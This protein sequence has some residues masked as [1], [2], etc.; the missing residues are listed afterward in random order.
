MAAL[1]VVL[2][3]VGKVKM[4]LMASCDFLTPLR[5]SRYLASVGALLHTTYYSVVAQEYIT[6]RYPRLRLRF[7]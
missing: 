5:C 3:A 6:I 2:V 1:V 4:E 7:R